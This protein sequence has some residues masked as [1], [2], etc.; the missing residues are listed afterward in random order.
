[1]V[2]SIRLTILEVIR[3]YQRRPKV[4]TVV[5]P[6]HWLSLTSTM[7]LLLFLAVNKIARSIKR[8]WESRFR[9]SNQQLRSQSMTPRKSPVLISFL[10]S[11]TPLRKESLTGQKLFLLVLKMNK[12][13]PRKQPFK[14]TRKRIQ[15]QQLIVI[16]SYP[17]SSGLADE[18]KLLRSRTGLVMKI[19]S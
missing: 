15:A 10:T 12:M 7:E 8:I 1:M 2:S 19:H 3:N 18:I 4:K 6:D 5:L 14:S 16:S 9:I 13:L 17:F 11:G